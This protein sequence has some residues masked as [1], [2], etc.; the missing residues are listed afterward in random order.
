[1]SV[2]LNDSTP[3]APTTV[4]GAKNVR[5]QQDASGNISAYHENGDVP[6][7]LTPVDLTAQGA[8]IAATNLVA[9]ASVVTNG[10]FM[11]KAYIIVT[12]VATT[13]STLPSVVITWTDPDNSTAQ[14]FT[15]TPT[16]TGN[17]LTTFQQA[18]MII[19]AKAA[20]AIQYSTTGFTSVG[21][22]AMQYALHLVPIAL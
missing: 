9:G 3:A 22:T 6:V 17:A 8:N 4:N 1:M 10:R 21:G 19:S 14:T 18:T 12:Q 13:S 2:N 15:L 5:W 20:T 11:I 16:N 7:E